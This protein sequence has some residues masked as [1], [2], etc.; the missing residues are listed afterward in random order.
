MRRICREVPGPC[1]A[2]NVET[3]RSPLL[4]AAELQA[5]GYAAVV[6]PVAAT[7]AVA[8]TLAELFATLRRTGTT[9]EFVPRMLDFD[10]FNELV[11]LAAQRE[12]E[13]KLQE[14]AESL[15]RRRTR[16]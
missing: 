5:I 10:A 7:Y 6:F 2:N 14:F 15:V 13:A 9:A 12:R 4:P 1:M 3:G 11:G 8:R 16:A